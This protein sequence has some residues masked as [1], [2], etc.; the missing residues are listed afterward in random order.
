M[1]RFEA[2]EFAPAER[3]PSLLVG[4]VATVDVMLQ[5]AMANASVAVGAAPVAA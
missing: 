5:L 2:P 3:T 4:Q 1:I